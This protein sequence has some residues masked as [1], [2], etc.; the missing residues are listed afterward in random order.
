MNPSF[1]P[2]KFREMLVQILF[3]KEVGNS[4]FDDLAELLMQE[5][6]VSMSQFEA[7]HAKA[8]L[9]LESAKQLDEKIENLSQSYEVE[10]IGKV[11]KNILRLSLYE[12]LENQLP[13]EVIIA[14]AIRLTKKFSSDS[15]VSF[16][17]ALLNGIVAD[18]KN[19]S[20]PS[21]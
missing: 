18:G 15:S 6:K 16:V 11:E 8:L 19:A 3:S 10:R 4:Q 12:L 1:S 5:L 20:L 7:A 2:K 21:P 14:E 9:I 17:T 13:L